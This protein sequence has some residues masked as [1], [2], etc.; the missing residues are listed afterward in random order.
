MEIKNEFSTIHQ[1]LLQ[2]KNSTDDKKII[3]GDVA[4]RYILLVGV[5]PPSSGGAPEVG[6]L[7]GRPRRRRGSSSTTNRLTSLSP[8]T[9]RVRAVAWYIPTG[10]RGSFKLATWYVVGEICLQIR[11]GHVPKFDLQCRI[12]ER[13]DGEDR[14]VFWMF[15]AILIEDNFDFH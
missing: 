1:C 9:E 7:G 5:T 15:I 13:R 14:L 8:G 11:H 2:F 12:L 4:S 10:V 6:C 3:L